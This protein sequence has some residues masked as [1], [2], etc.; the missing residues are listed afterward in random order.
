[1]SSHKFYFNPRNLVLSQGTPALLIKLLVAR[2][3]GWKAPIMELK[4]VIYDVEEYLASQRQLLGQAGSGAKQADFETDDS[5]FTGHEGT[6]DFRPS[7]E[8]LVPEQVFDLKPQQGNGVIAVATLQVARAEEQAE[9]AALTRGG[10]SSWFVHNI[11]ETDFLS[12]RSTP[13]EID[14]KMM[15]LM[16]EAGNFGKGTLQIRKIGSIGFN[17]EALQASLEKT[18]HLAIRLISTRDDQ[19]PLKTRQMAMSSLHKNENTT[20]GSLSTRKIAVD[21]ALAKEK[22]QAPGKPTPVNTDSGAIPSRQKTPDLTGWYEQHIDNVEGI[23]PDAD[24]Y[25]APSA[26]W[27][28]QVGQ[29]IVGWYYPMRLLGLRDDFMGAARN[30]V[31]LGERICFVTL[32][33]PKFPNDAAVY[34]FFSEKK[35]PTEI[36]ARIREEDLKPSITIREGLFKVIE[37]GSLIT[38]V[39]LA[40]TLARVLNDGS[41]ADQIGEIK[42]AK[43][44]RSYSNSRIA[45][46]SIQQMRTI[47]NLNP[48]GVDEVVR[49]RVEPLPSGFWRKIATTLQDD[50]TRIV[51]NFTRFPNDDENVQAQ[52]DAAAD[53]INGIV[54]LFPNEQYRQE[55]LN[56]VRSF[57]NSMEFD[58]FTGS[59]TKLLVDWLRSFSE[60]H[61]ELEIKEEAAAQGVAELTPEER[62]EI[63]EE[64]RAKKGGVMTDVGVVPANDFEYSFKFKSKSGTKKAQ[65]GAS[66]GVTGGIF[67]CEI[68]QREIK[69]GTPLAKEIYSVKLDG[70]FLGIGAGFQVDFAGGK[71]GQPGASEPPSCKIRSFHPIEK[72]EWQQRFPN[73]VGFS[74]A[75]LATG[76]SGNFANVDIKL[77][78]ASSTLFSLTFFGNRD[79]QLSAILENAKLYEFKPRDTDKILEDLKEGK[80]AQGKATLFSI[81]ETF[82]YMTSL[83]FWKDFVPPKTPVPQLP[84]Q[85]VPLDTL[86]DVQ[87]V[88]FENGSAVILEEAKLDFDRRL[89]V[90]RAMMEVAGWFWS[91]GFASPGWDAH[92][93]KADQKNQALSQARADA[94]DHLLAASIGAPGGGI[95]FADKQR[96]APLGAGRK[97]ALTPVAD[98]GGGLHDP[99]DPE[100]PKEVAIKEDWFD[101]AKW[102]RVDLVVNATLI[103][104]LKAP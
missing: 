28:N 64:I 55:A 35:D 84:D 87:L 52:F 98:G 90:Y 24:T 101:Y 99:Y 60:K 65:G 17:K 56:W 67:E 5:L 1:M 11:I 48:A 78:N 20:G 91:V 39:A 82:G 54:A 57:T 43:F 10:N 100:T 80:I 59:E 34:W 89:A 50:M 32:P 2:E 42:F 41:P 27:I 26:L 93:E 81:S 4:M 37:A 19:G 79:I 25:L 102:R 29:A 45:W 86:S 70:A 72:K 63:A 83:N 104:R 12:H 62:Q 75:A 71:V 49:S 9:I 13:F 76:I 6:V 15:S 94:V 92:P 7:R 46:T 18:R 66:F 74:M 103:A 36:I 53:S 73:G 88:S 40:L 22:L 21:I 85:D 97:P 30:H 95:V 33:S 38:D 44:R 68:Q 96:I 69:N 14:I 31:P 8:L 58:N 61:L 47:P 23:D 16:D 51:K 77:L 3:A